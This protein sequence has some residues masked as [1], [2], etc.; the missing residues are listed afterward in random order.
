[1]IHV[2][3]QKPPDGQFKL[4][5]DGSFEPKTT[6]GGTRGILGNHLGDWIAGFACKIKVENAYHAELLTLLHGLTLAKEKNFKHIMVETDSQVLLNS[7]NNDSSQY[8]HICAD[9]RSLLQQLGAPPLKHVPREANGTANALAEYGKKSR[10]QI[11]IG[12]KLYIFYASPSCITYELD[13]DA[14]G[15]GSLRSVPLCMDVP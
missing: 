8:S 3:W 1:M 9:C 10:D 4:N 2:S 12:N 7:L 13:R 6:N 11:M 5:V 15:T 14:N